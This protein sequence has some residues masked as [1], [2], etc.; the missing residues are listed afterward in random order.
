MADPQLPPEQQLVASGDRSG[1]HQMLYET[2][3]SP[4]APTS[5]AQSPT[6]PASA[7]L[8]SVDLPREAAASTAAVEEPHLAALQAAIQ[9]ARDCGVN[10]SFVAAQEAK[11]EA[12]RGK[13]QQAAAGEAHEKAFTIWGGILH[14][15]RPQYVTAGR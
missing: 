14:M 5:A 2:S 13:Q 1:N 8:N 11:L 10:P 12:L 15:M 4:T 7:A 3:H 6:A 9:R